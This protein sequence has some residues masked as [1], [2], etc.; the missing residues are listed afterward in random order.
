LSAS[1][2]PYTLSELFLSGALKKLSDKERSIVENNLASNI[3]DTVQAAYDEAQRKKTICEDKRW[4]ISAKASKVVLWL[5][6]FK[7]VVDVGVNADPINAGLPWT[8]VKLL[9]TVLGADIKQMNALMDGMEIALSVASRL[10]VYFAYFQ[11]LPADDTTDNLRSALVELYALLLRFFAQAIRIYSSSTASRTV[12]AL[13]QDSEITLFD[14]RSV[15]LGELVEVEIHNCDRHLGAKRNEDAA[16]WRTELDAK[17]RALDGIAKLEVSL[18]AL[19]A[20]VDLSK[21]LVVP[22][23]KF[24]STEESQLPDCLGGTRVDLLQLILDWS[25][26]PTGKCIF[27][28]CGKAGT[29]KSTISRTVSRMLEHR[30]SL[31]ASFFFK[32]GHE[33]R[34]NADKFFTTIVAQLADR[35]PVLRE[36]IARVLNDDSFICASGL[37]DQFDKLLREPLESINL[38]QLPRDGLTIVIDAL[39]ECERKYI[40]KFLSLLASINSITSLRL[41]IFVTSRPELPI[42]IGFQNIDGRLHEDVFLEEVQALTI[43]TDLRMYFIHEFASI[44]KEW[45]RASLPPDWPSAMMIDRLVTIA[46]PLFIF[47][48][49]VCRFVSEE[50]PRSRLEGILSQ[51]H[52]VSS[53]RLENDYTHLRMIYAQIL[54]QV[55]GGSGEYTDDQQVERIK[56]VVGPIVLLADPLSVASL[57]RLLQIEVK[58]IE[59]VVTRLKS[60]LFVPQDIS[61]PVQTLHLS[62]REYLV[63]SHN[64]ANGQFK[65]DE[66]QTHAELARRCIQLLTESTALRKNIC[67][68]SSLDCKRQ[69]ITESQIAQ[70]I[71]RPNAYAC[72]YW[73][74]HLVAC[75][76]PITDDH[77]IHNFLRTHMLHW[78]EAMSW[79]GKYT[80]AI[81][82]IADLTGITNVRAHK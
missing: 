72:M 51:E 46:T 40:K 65:V 66:K 32:R 63:D 27:W 17:L 30:K 41:R 56:S 11:Q 2:Q 25:E 64:R 39:D 60:V 62:F 50:S 12:Q 68:V 16:Q 57:S 5:D 78:L 22:S 7:G 42:E 81:T 79:L 74:H 26:E 34:G 77:P 55:S 59:Y 73:S 9:L 21:L 1:A 52:A 48:A 47:A 20:K 24:N 80:L 37:Q 19:Q 58:S 45:Q 10:R 18:N 53:L 3:G 6:R 36:P 76:D 15:A 33:G 70:Y 82:S 28:L 14:K 31:G 75:G 35:I 29:G 8:G 43:E 49:T 4:P 13:W 71:P 23:A 69:E 38:A 67:R 61:Q 44:R 54:Q